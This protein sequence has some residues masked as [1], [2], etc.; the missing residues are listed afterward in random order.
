MYFVFEF[1]LLDFLDFY[2]W[3]FF[4]RFYISEDWR[5]VEIFGEKI[6]ESF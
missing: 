5:G 4:V 3:L 6:E 1:F 2:L